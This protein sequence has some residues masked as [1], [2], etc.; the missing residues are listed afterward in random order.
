[1]I[2]TP[3][4]GGAFIVKTVEFKPLLKSGIITYF[5]IKSVKGIPS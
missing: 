1:M 2:G 3:H 5:L 4:K